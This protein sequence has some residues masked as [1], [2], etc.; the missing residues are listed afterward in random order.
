MAVIARILL[1]VEKSCS[2]CK[3]CICNYQAP[4]AQGHH[5]GGVQYEASHS[6]CAAGPAEVRS[7]T[8]YVAFNSDSS[9]P[10]LGWGLP[11]QAILGN[12]VTVESTVHDIGSRTGWR[13]DQVLELPASL[14]SSTFFCFSMREVAARAMIS[15]LDRLWSL[16]NP[17]RT[18]SPPCQPPLS[19]WS[20]S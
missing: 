4:S 5:S 1:E 18:N 13:T 8:E 2:L 20:S 6:A 15:L 17:P 11:Y 12:R 16:V 10:G 7:G 19:A 3:T 14:C 9:V